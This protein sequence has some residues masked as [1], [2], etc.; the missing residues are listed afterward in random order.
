MSWMNRCLVTRNTKRFDCHRDKI[1]YGRQCGIFCLFMAFSV[2]SQCPRRDNSM[3]T[4]AA[5]K[6]VRIR[7]VPDQTASIVPWHCS[8]A[9]RPVFVVR[10]VTVEMRRLYSGRHTRGRQSH[11]A[12]WMMSLTV[13]CRY[14]LPADFRQLRPCVPYA[15][16][17]WPRAQVC[18]S[19]TGAPRRN[20]IRRDVLFSLVPTDE[21]GIA[22]ND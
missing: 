15:L 5:C 14:C 20:A 11:K 4:V 10:L 1:V 17:A 16:T 2:G 9:I 8:K 21:H 13:L 3:V 22:C 19:H 18:G 7:E 12:L 6:S